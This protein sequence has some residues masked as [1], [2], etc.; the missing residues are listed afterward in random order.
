MFNSYIYS[1]SH[2]KTLFT[3]EKI[4]QELGICAGMLTGK[5][6]LIRFQTWET[7]FIYQCR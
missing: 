2:C 6:L 4:L 1:K 3:G 5:I 7:P